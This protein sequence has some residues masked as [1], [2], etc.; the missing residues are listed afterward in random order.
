M[1]RIIL[2]DDQPLYLDALKMVL[3]G[4]ENIEI[5][6]VANNGIEL[7]KLLENNKV[8]ALL[9]DI[10]MPEMNGIEA[11]AIIKEKYPDIKIIMLTMHKE[12]NIIKQLLKIG[13]HAYLL[14]NTSKDEIVMVLNK[15]VDGGTYYGSEVKEALIDSFV[16]QGMNN[17]IV[18]NQHEKDI[19]TLICA[20][21]ST[22][23]LIQELKLDINMVFQNKS[24][25]Y[26]KLEV[27][28]DTSLIRYAFE[29]NLIEFNF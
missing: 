21:N 14:K 3:K 22:R 11:S 6:A 27:E 28:D 2:T 7:M 4:E 24:S 17:N 25:L 15:V 1:I 13:V 19:L 18:L 23:Q 20:G 9:L 8:N 26:E 29:N 5:V 16:E 10:N 12:V